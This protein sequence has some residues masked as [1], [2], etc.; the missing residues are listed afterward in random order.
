MESKQ[1]D[2]TAEDAGPIIDWVLENGGIATFHD[3][4]TELLVNEI[5]TPDF[6]VVNTEKPGKDIYLLEGDILRLKSNG[7]FESFN[8]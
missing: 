2:G 8:F 3:K 1:W 4:E 6:I 7:K 5:V